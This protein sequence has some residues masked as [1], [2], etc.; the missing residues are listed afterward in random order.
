[1]A[2]IAEIVRRSKRLTIGTEILLTKLGLWA[3]AIAFL[4]N[5]SARNRACHFA[6][7]LYRRLSN[8]HA[9]QLLAHN[10]VEID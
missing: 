6:V 9:L 5:F 4:Y 7:T 10:E 2:E 3:F 8:S 1:M